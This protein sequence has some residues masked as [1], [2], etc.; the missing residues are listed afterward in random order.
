VGDTVSSS[1]SGGRG[2]VGLI[3]GGGLLVF[4]DAVEQVCE[5]G[6]GEFPVEGPCGLVV[7]A[8]EGKQGAAE[9]VEA[10]EV[11]RRDTFFWMTEKKISIWFSQEAWTGVW[12]MTAFG[13]ALRS[14]SAAAWPRG[15]SR[16]P[17]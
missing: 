12:I 14:L 10:G 4:A 11:I 13:C 1:G 16:Y 3:C 8:D 5:V 2:E 17:R 9:L 15:P 7:A 6:G